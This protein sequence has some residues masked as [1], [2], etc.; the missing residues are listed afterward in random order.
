MDIYSEPEAEQAAQELT[1]DQEQVPAIKE[2]QERHWEE[3]KRR[4]EEEEVQ[5]TV[6][7][8]V[9]TKEVEEM[10]ERERQIQLQ[11]SNRFLW[12]LT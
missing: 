4:E 7:M 8:E 1:Q 5:L 3:C 6:V 9:A 12:N 2:A 11:V 10:L